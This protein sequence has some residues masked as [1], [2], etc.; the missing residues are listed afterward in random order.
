[1]LGNIA[2]V[3][4]SDFARPQAVGYRAY[5]IYKKAK[6]RKLNIEVFC[7]DTWKEEE[8]VIKVVPMGGKIS[9]ALNAFRILV[10]PKFNH[11]KY[12]NALFWFFL[13]KHLRKK[14]ISLIHTF[15]D[16]VFNTKVPVIL[17]MPMAHPIYVINVLQKKGIFL[18]NEIKEVPNSL[19]KA[20]NGANVIIAPSQFVRDSLILAGCKDEKIKIIPFGVGIRKKINCVYIENKLKQSDKLIFLFMGS[21]NFRKGIPYLLKAWS[22]LNL[23][24]AEL[25]I[26][27]RIYKS[28]K[29]FLKKENLNLSNVKFW[30][31]QTDTQKFLEKAHIYLFPTLFEGSSK[32]VY[33]AMSFGLPVITTYNAG[34]IVEDGKEGF[35]IPIA[36]VDAIC[37]RVLY[38]YKE[39]EKIIEMGI[40]AF[41]KVKNFTWDIYGEKVLKIYGGFL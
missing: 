2:L 34:S 17:D 38:F 22:K 39:P 5:W 30:G 13:K 23:K 11:R 16:F 25:W 28:V 37:E 29:N 18:D 1:M 20:I 31:F 24:D 3:L 40:R 33:E 7:R 27:G 36:D 8:G 12:D 15:E 14:E 35:I 6:E 21:V 26:L 10:Y 4:N 41:E 9:R 19:K 32:S